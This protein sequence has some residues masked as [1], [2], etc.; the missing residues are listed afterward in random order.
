MFSTN[1]FSVALTRRE[2]PE[3]PNYACSSLMFLQSDREIFKKDSSD[4]IS[5]I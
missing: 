5:F 1:A 3:L 4:L 2:L